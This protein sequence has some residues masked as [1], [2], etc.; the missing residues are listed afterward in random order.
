M[1]RP[2]GAAGAGV[3][4]V[5]P[6]LRRIGT[7]PRWAETVGL[8]IRPIQEVSRLS[9]WLDDQ[10][11]RCL[12]RW[13]RSRGFSGLLCRGH[14]VR[15]RDGGSGARPHVADEP[16]RSG[17]HPRTRDGEPCTAVRDR[18]RRSGS[19]R[20]RVR[21]GRAPRNACRVP[22]HRRAMGC[23][24]LLRGGSERHRDQRARPP[25]LIRVTDPS[26]RRPHGAERPTVEVQSGGLERGEGVVHDDHRPTR[27]VRQGGGGRVG[28]EFLGDPSAGGTASMPWATGGFGDGTSRSGYGRPWTFYQPSG[29]RPSRHRCR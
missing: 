4:R 27:V 15:G 3:A 7:R 26:S 2:R 21:R 9:P 8:P 6:R 23:P 16:H 22:A 10:K 14:G 25:V 17:P 11:S 24:A 29:A 20:R 13:R 12:R 19:G 18:H 28:G 5:R 1:A